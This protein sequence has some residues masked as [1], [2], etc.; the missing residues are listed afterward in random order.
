[1]AI[2][3]SLGLQLQRIQVEQGGLRTTLLGEQITGEQNKNALAGVNEEILNERLT[4]LKEQVR[5]AR[6]PSTYQAAILEIDQAIQE[7]D[8]SEDNYSEQ[9]D[10]LENRKEQ[11]IA[12]L[13]LYT[14]ATTRKTSSGDPKFPS[15]VNAY[16][17]SLAGKMEKQGF[18]LGTQLQVTDNGI[19]WIGTKEGD[20]YKSYQQIRARH[21][22]QYFIAIE[23]Y[24]QGGA[25]AQALGLQTPDDIPM[26][27]V[28]RQVGSPGGGG[29]IQ[30][31]SVI[32]YA[33]TD[34]GDIYQH[35]QFGLGQIVLDAR[36][37][38]AFDTF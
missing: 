27:D 37:R 8:P 13:A 36:G 11:T 35:P 5:D 25:A 16:N 18:V 17:K 12:S 9:K 23:G 22:A 1:V 21:D 4:L 30:V 31:D 6:N 3:A 2:R 20:A 14:D 26:T 34:V 15:L 19:S 32:D 29:M 24:E 7:L 10:L 33:A 38:K 28:E